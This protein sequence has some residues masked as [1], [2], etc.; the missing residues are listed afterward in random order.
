V[1]GNLDSAKVAEQKL[2]VP[3]NLDS[4]KIAEIKI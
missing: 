1:P 4:A 2:Q 3:G